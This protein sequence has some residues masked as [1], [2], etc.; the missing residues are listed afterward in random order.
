M[1]TQ[2]S[3]TAQH[4]KAFQ[5]GLLMANAYILLDSGIASQPFIDAINSAVRDDGYH[6]LGDDMLAMSLPEAPQD[7]VFEYLPAANLTTSES[8][9]LKANIEQFI[10][11]AFRE[12]QAY[13]GVT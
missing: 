6:G 9:T 4:I 1:T 2:K 10:R 12:N 8:E 13:S 11:C 3:A 5:V 7:I